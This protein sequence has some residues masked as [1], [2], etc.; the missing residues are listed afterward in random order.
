MISAVP[1]KRKRKTKKLPKGINIIGNG[2]INNLC[3]RK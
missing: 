3:Q 1:G 2:N